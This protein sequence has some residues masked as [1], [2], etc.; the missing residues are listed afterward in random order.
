VIWVNVIFR[1]NTTV[2]VG[3]IVVHEF[4]GEVFNI[5][6]VPRIFTM[7]INEWTGTERFWVIWAVLSS[8]FIFSHNNTVMDFT[9]VD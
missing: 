7:N 8:P 5:W 3:V 9:D 1:V 4:I 6:T 2:S